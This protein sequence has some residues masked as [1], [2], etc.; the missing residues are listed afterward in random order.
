MTVAASATPIVAIVKPDLRRTAERRY[1]ASIWLHAAALARDDGSAL[2]CVGASGAG[3]STAAFALLAAGWQY[4]NDD[5]VLFDPV[6]RT[7]IGLDRHLHLAT[8]PF[9]RATLAAAGFTVASDTR[10]GSG[11]P[12]KS[13]FRLLPPPSR[14]WSGTVPAR[15]DRCLFLER[16]PLALEP[17]TPGQALLRLWPR[18]ICR[19]DGR[20]P[21]EPGALAARLAGVQF[22][23]LRTE[24]IDQVVPAV[25]GWMGGQREGTG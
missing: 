2:L 24:R 7:L 16:G 20:E 17:L 22:A 12:M 14:V 5:V 1:P 21:W 9:P 13:K 18:R 25:T 11:Q 3:K 15:F 19:N 8:L 10:G 6:D 4:L 23:V